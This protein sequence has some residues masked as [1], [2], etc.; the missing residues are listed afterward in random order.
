MP[1]PQQALRLSDGEIAAYLQHLEGGIFLGN[2]PPEP[3]T[4]VHELLTAKADAWRT[5]LLAQQQEQQQQ[6]PEQG[7][8]GQAPAPGES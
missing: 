7:S 2:K 1:A 3:L 8:I 6:Q 4:A 5:H